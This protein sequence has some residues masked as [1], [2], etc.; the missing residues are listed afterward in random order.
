MPTLLRLLPA[1][2]PTAIVPTAPCHCNCACD[3]DCACA[4]CDGDCDCDCAY[5]CAYYDACAYDSYCDGTFYHADCPRCFDCAPLRPFSAALLLLRC[6]SSS[7]IHPTAAVLVY[8]TK[9]MI[10]L[11][12]RWRRDVC[13][14]REEQRANLVMSLRVPVLQE[15]QAA[16][17]QKDR[18]SAGALSVLLR[19][20]CKLTPQSDE[21]LS[22]SLTNRGATRRLTWALSEWRP[23]RLMSNRLINFNES[24]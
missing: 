16:C 17:Y 6:P 14:C 21:R 22:V 3:G 10:A 12:S 19:G 24:N 13:T 15:Q 7:A 20:L 23:M 11:R 1:T 8:S 18:G 4:D 2:A 5:Y 9:M